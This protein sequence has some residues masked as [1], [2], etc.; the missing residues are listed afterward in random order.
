MNH[1]DQIHIRNFRLF[2]SLDI[3]HV[4][5][6]NL[7][8]GKNNCGKTTLLEALN[9]LVVHEYARF[10][11]GVSLIDVL[12]NRGDWNHNDPQKS[13]IKLF[14]ESTSNYLL[15]VNE[16]K[17]SIDLENPLNF[18]INQQE[19]PSYIGHNATMQ[20]TLFLKANFEL[21]GSA[22][23]NWSLI[24]LTPKED[25]VVRILKIIENRI[26]QV[27][28]DT[29]QK[30]AFV[31]LSGIA[32]PVPLK[33]FGEG[34]NRLLTI[35][36][37]LVNA[38]N[39]LLLIDEIDLGLHHSVQTKLWEIVFSTAK[40]LNVQ[41]FATTHSKDCVKAFS[42]VSEKF[43]GMANYLRLE[44]NRNGE[45]FRAVNYDAEML[46]TAVYHEMETR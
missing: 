13:L 42:E 26:E 8:T 2:D 43:E 29:A 34:M 25:E 3:E 9:I 24:R 18:I 38:E 27:D 37:G 19:I 7:I 45:G 41:V 4:G 15:S 28:V 36:L 46:E 20:S 33:N 35:A 32:N 23:N 44:K 30:S 11:T 6:V 40:R 21:D 1:L 5:Q 10:S 31:K 14:H 39:S 17:V 12:R 16:F 22:A